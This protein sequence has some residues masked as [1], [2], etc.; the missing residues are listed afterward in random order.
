MVGPRQDHRSANPERLTQH[1]KTNTLQRFNA[2]TA[3][4]CQ[5]WSSLVKP[6]KAKN[7][8]PDV[9]LLKSRP[10]DFATW[11]LV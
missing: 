11:Q 3:S 2:P 1:E 10:R 6:D 7:I 5:A 9:H 8:Y 4:G